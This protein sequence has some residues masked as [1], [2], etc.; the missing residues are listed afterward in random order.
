MPVLY[1]L[2]SLLKIMMVKTSLYDWW[3]NCI[4]FVCVLSTFVSIKVGLKLDV[5]DM[6]LSIK[7]GILL[8]PPDN[9]TSVICGEN[10]LCLSND[11]K[12]LQQ[13]VQRYNVSLSLSRVIDFL[14]YCC[15][16]ADVNFSYNKQITQFQKWSYLRDNLRPCPAHSLAFSIFPQITNE[17][18]ITLILWNK[19]LIRMV[20]DA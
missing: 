3:Q 7:I 19:A 13:F 10:S 16:G 2:S 9:F 11:L 20:L 5:K 15:D 12:K 4:N 14:N 18:F 1:I 6:I 17:L 8:D